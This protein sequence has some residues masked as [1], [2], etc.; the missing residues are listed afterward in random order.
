MAE[1][2]LN[3]G[4]K[5]LHLRAVSSRAKQLVQGSVCL[6]Q[7]AAIYRVTQTGC[8]G[9]MVSILQRLTGAFI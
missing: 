6:K 7:P 8:R 3:P 2:M 5:Y 1:N 4:S 9:Q